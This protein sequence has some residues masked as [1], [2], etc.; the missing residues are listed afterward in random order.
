MNGIAPI[1]RLALA[2]GAGLAVGLAGAPSWMA[3]LL[4]IGALVLPIGTSG[5]PGR[6]VTLAVGG[7][8]WIAALVASVGGCAAPD[9]GARERIVGYFVASP[10]TGSA[11]FVRA[12]GCGAI[13]VVVADSLSGVKLAGRPTA[14][15]G[16]WRAGSWRPWFS[17]RSIEDLRLAVDDP[18]DGRDA[19]LGDRRRSVTGWAQQGAARWRDE[20]VARLYGLYGGRAP[21]VAA[22]VFARREGLDRDLREDFAVSG[23][24]HLLAISGF[25]VGVI[26]GLALAFL[27]AVRVPKRRAG[28]GAA[29]FAWLYVGFIGFPDAACRAAFILVAVAVSRSIGRP[30][31]RWS[32]LAG[33][34]LALLVSDPTRLS[35]AGFQLSFAG[36]AGL[37]AW[38][39]SLERIL[40]DRG[41]RALSALC[42]VTSGRV[43]VGSPPRAL[44]SAVAAG[45]AATVATVP[46]VAWHFGRVSLVGIPATLAASPLVSLALPGAL[47]TIVLDPIAPRATAFLAGGVEALLDVLVVQTSAAA[48]LP[49]VSL[50]VSRTT[51]IAAV[52]GVVV[53]HRIALHPRIR[54]VARRRLVVA[55]GL[56]G[57]LLW[58]VAVSLGGRGSLE[59]FFIDVG[60]GDAIAVRT[61]AGRWL[62][63][64]A[65][66]PGPT[67]PGAHPVVR[68]LRARGVARLEMFVLTHADADHFGGATAVLR[69]FDVRRVYDPMLPA[70]KRAYAE[71]LDLARRAGIVWE[72]ARSGSRWIV[73][74]VSIRVMHPP[75]LEGGGG[76]EIEDANASSAILLLSWK[77]FDVLLTGDAYVDV[78]RSIMREVGDIEVLK[79]GH[80]GSTT[81]SD[82]TFLRVVGPE[83]A[84]ISVG[85]GNR[86]GHPAPSVLR[87]LEAVGAR[88]LRTDLQGDIR[89]VV[90]PNGA[91]STRTSR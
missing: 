83:V 87:R 49:W 7:V 37:V 38:S 25:H 67:D 63:V 81:S 46:I 59:L 20:L 79:V 28:L 64:D 11:P 74:G 50:W 40:N 88:I 14:I 78:E 9:V 42:H 47:M 24:A 32:A 29:A 48:S 39:G 13:T 6:G 1:V 90:E 72:P 77:E 56:S 57:V 69:S 17:A 23:I 68:A 18:T 8:G 54:G 58:P 52:A 70:P 43:D 19:R 15:V 73:D 27:R 55:Y 34:A 45:V 21:L 62:L 89:L 51:V 4:G 22:L 60:Q 3:P 41:R 12:D 30:P 71:V 31:T 44:L 36:A 66:R 26:A 86:Y 35:S 5:R 16:D 2:Y 82:S 75:P 33:A 80:H 10:R 65:G 76:I 91:L 53:A 84:V 61:P 85:R